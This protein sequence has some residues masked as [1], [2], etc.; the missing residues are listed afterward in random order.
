MARIS[1]STESGRDSELPVLVVH[2]RERL[3]PIALTREQPVAQL[4]LDR[5]V[6]VAVL[7]QP[8][9][10]GLLGLGRGLVDE[11]DP[12][13]RLG[14]LEHMGDRWEEVC[15]REQQLQFAFVDGIKK[16]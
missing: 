4:V 3:T 2:D 7:L 9:D 12:L 8:T 13:E 15:R 14:A 6:A 16:T 1:A 10:D 11:D 5:A